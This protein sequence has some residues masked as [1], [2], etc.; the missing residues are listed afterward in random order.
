[1]EGMRM[2]V[3]EAEVF[4]LDDDTKSLR[5]PDAALGE[6][7]LAKLHEQLAV[8][9]SIDG[10]GLW[11]WDAASDGVWA[12]PRARSILG[13][14]EYE[15]LT[16]DNLLAAVHPADVPRV[17]QA[18]GSTTR[19]GDLVQ[20]ELRVAGRGGEIRWIT[21]KSAASRD[22]KGALASVTGCVID[23]S[24]RRE[25]EEEL[26]KQQRQITHLTRVAMLGELSG[27]LAHELQQPLTAI[28]CNAQA[29]QML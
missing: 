10:L 2:A 25:A 12:S 28:L 5:A 11:S 8:V 1:M 13:L 6:K 9:S 17:L 20:L 18:I 29:A 7:L 27:A 14:D 21:A 24:Q 23:D 3:V 19:M 16:R 15:L 26:A 22:A 4:V